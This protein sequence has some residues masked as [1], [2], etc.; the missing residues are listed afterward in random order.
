[1]KVAGFGFQ[2]AATADALLDALQTAGGPA[3]ISLLATAAGKTDAPALRE[4]A[5]EL[6]L[7]IRAITPEALTAAPVQYHSARVEALYGTGSVAEAAALCA[8][9]A[10]ARLVCPRVVSRDGM[11]TAAI[12]EVASP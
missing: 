2:S 3:G 12:A 10:G 1:M 4:L 6:G 7:S 8:A 9:G 5:T 11:A